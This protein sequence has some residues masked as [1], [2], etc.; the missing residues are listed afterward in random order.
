M[1]DFLKNN[2]S[3]ITKESLK[4]GR[5]PQKSLV[6]NLDDVINID[7]SLVDI[8]S[9]VTKEEFSPFAHKIKPRKQFFIVERIK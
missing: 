3:W 2:K 6:K 1:L 7:Y 5:T 4:K 9:Y 8:S